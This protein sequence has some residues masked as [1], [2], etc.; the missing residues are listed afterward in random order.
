MA[1]REQLAVRADDK[2]SPFSGVRDAE[3]VGQS[4]VSL[5]LRH[6][7]EAAEPDFARCGMVQAASDIPRIGRERRLEIGNLTR[8]NH[9]TNPVRFAL[10][11]PS[12]VP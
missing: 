7:V 3:S 8:W 12:A 4:L 10:Q 6:G 1:P 9:A 2:P 5:P 11:P